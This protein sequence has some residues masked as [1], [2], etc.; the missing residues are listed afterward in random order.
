[1]KSRYSLIVKVL[2]AVVVLL[3]GTYLIFIVTSGDS[4]DDKVNHKNITNH[5]DSDIDNRHSGN[6]IAYGLKSIEGENI[7]NGTVLSIEDNQ[8]NVFVSIDHNI[9]EK[10]EY[11]LIILEDFKQVEFRVDDQKDLNKHFFY[12][13]PNSSMDIKVTLS[14]NKNSNELT[15][16]IIKKPNYVLREMD[17]VR[18]GILEEV[19]SL[20]HPLNH[21]K[22]SKV[23]EIA[24]PDSIV[25]DG[26]NEYIFVTNNKEKLQSVIME[27]EG[28]NLLLSNGNDTDRPITYAILAFKDWEQSKII[29][30]K[31]VL[32]TTVSPNERQLFDF[33]LPQVSKD[34]NFQFIALPYPYEV[35]EDNYISQQAFGSFR[36]LIQ[37]KE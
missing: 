22:S 4:T 12:M 29:R 17:F 5:I 28:S 35:S 31:N 27:I 25:K 13:E 7:D 2:L 1:M 14:V 9:D 10:R 15:F 34:T 20:R 3:V 16:L 26:L 8:V 23:A 32:F 30:N 33:K 11:G 24:K 18:V 21:G 6:T 36:V 37:N 19:L